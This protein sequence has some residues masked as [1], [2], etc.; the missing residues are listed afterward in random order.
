MSLSLLRV[1]R[2]IFVDANNQQMPPY[3]ME[4]TLHFSKSLERRVMSL[5]HAKSVTVRTHNG[6]IELKDHGLLNLINRYHCDTN[7]KEF[8]IAWNQHSLHAYGYVLE[9]IEVDYDWSSE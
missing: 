2:F 9:I 5:K 7:S 6:V 4:R 1:R 3:A 8:V